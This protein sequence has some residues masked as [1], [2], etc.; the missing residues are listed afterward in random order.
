[1][2]QQAPHYAMRYYHHVHMVGRRL[3]TMIIII[4]S[5]GGDIYDLEIYITCVMCTYMM[6][7]IHTY[8]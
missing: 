6:H 3:Y 5:E 7:D 8:I 4:L 1:M 2:H